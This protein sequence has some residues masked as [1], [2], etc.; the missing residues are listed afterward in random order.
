MAKVIIKHTVDFIEYEYKQ[1]PNDASSTVAAPVKQ[2]R[3]NPSPMSQEIPSWCTKTKH[4]E[5]LKSDGS[6]VEVA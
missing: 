2:F 4:Y 1:H 6:L 5:L 3:L